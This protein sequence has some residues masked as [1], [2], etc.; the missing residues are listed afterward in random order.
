MNGMRD[1]EMAEADEHKRNQEQSRDDESKRRGLSE[2]ASA[3]PKLAAET[4]AAVA[5]V[6]EAAAHGNEVAK[7][8]LIIETHNN[9][10]WGGFA[11]TLAASKAHLL[12]LQEIHAD[13]KKDKEL[14]SLAGKLGW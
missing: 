2:E 1:T 8:G 7:L 4:A 6:N 10:S 3:A 14:R 9:A 13:Q 12:M 5:K 11:E